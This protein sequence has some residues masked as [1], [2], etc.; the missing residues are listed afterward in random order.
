MLDLGDDVLAYKINYSDMHDNVEK[1]VE[2]Q[3]SI[4]TCL[5]QNSII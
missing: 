1:Q 2:K 3:R 4:V 5:L